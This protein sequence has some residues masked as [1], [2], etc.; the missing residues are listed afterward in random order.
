MDKDNK[1]AYCECGQKAVVICD[2]EMAETDR[3]AMQMFYEAACKG[4]NIDY[5]S[6]EDF[7]KIGMCSQRN[8]TCPNHPDNVAK[9]QSD[10][11]SQQTKLF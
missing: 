2:K 5:I 8:G 6:T 1:I 10:I 7:Q 3:D 4:Y 9:Q 11:N